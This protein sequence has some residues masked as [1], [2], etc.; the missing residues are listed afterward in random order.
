[1]ESSISVDNPAN[2]C[3]LW[4]LATS[5]ILNDVSVQHSVNALQCCCVVSLSVMVL[6]FVT[7]ELTRNYS[8]V[9]KLWSITP[10]IYAFILVSD[11]RTLLMALLVFVWGCRLT[12][13]FYRR[14]GFTWPP[15]AGDEDYRWKYL[16]EGFLWDGLRNP[17]VWKCF[18]LLF[19]S[20]YQ[21]LLL[22]LIVGPS[23]IAHLVA[24][25][26]QDMHDPSLN[27]W[28]IC[29][30]ILYL[31]FVAVETLADN[32]Q[33]QFQEEKYRRR[34]TGEELAGDYKNGFNRSG[35]F[36]VVRK[37]NYA[38]EQAIWIVF[39]LFSISCF[40]AEVRR[41]HFIN[42]SSIGWILLVMLFQGSGYFTEKI[43]LS[44]YPNYKKYMEETPL[45]VPNPFQLL[46]PASRNF[47][48]S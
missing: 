34:A 5:E 18:N 2:N 16:Q 33:F 44:K 10:C 46:R 30:S 22:M 3:L 12:L 43:S 15:W 27:A 4:Q 1:M 6:T 28:D 39:Y 24:T 40:H 21:N 41:Q 9:D 42:W 23:A 8:Q 11:T 38:C 7:S 29:G 31:G 45:Y 35:L 17:L 19:I 20:V 13:N 36:A 48:E 32:Q 37:P 26:C 47:K 14:G 25:R